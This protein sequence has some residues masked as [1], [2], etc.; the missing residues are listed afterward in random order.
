MT[1]DVNKPEESYL[2]KFARIAEEKRTSDLP[3]AYDLKPEPEPAETDISSQL[4]SSQSAREWLASLSANNSASAG[5]KAEEPA[6]KKAAEVSASVQE[7]KVASSSVSSTSS[8]SSESPFTANAGRDGY[9]EKKK[10]SPVW[11]FVLLALLLGLGGVAG[12]VFLARNI[13]SSAGQS[14]LSPGELAKKRENTLKLVQKYIEAGLYDKALS[15]LNDL[16]IDDPGDEAV[17]SIFDQVASLSRQSMALGGTSGFYDEQGNF[18]P[19]SIGPGGETGFY[20]SEGNFHA[21]TT[22]PGGKKGYYDSEGNFHEMSSATS[23][24]G[25]GQGAYP[26]AAGGGTAGFYDAQGNYHP[27]AVGPDGTVGYYGSDGKFHSANEPGVK[28]VP[29]SGAAGLAGTGGTAGFYDAQGNYHPA[30]V[31]PDGSVGYYDSTGKFHSA[32]E[33][34]VTAVPAAGAA[35]LAGMNGADS[36]SSMSD[37]MQATIDAL[38]GE[39]A[40]QTEE[41]VRTNQALRDELARQTA[42]SA[43]SNQ[44]L[45]DELA[46]QTAESAKSNQALRDEL[47][48]QNAENAKSTQALKDQL[49]KQTEENRKNVQAMNDLVR[50]QKE[51]EE[52]R[53]AAEAEEK[54]RQEAEAKQRAAEEKKRKE[55]EARKAAESAAAA[56]LIKD[57]NDEI[58]KGKAALNSGDVDEAMKHFAKAKS[59]LPANDK[60]FYAD[61]MGEMSSALYDA[62]QNTQDSAQK[63]KLM[64]QALGYANDSLAKDSS[65]PESHYIKAMDAFDSKN[66]AA[67]EAELKK[68]VAA[69][70][71]NPNY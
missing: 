36:S 44:A 20:D 43:K 6:P 22:G 70:P 66:W 50:A 61:K 64:Q 39:L 45:M 18:H 8:I 51:A 47:A 32:G 5:Y 53:R 12:G 3:S 60:E 1:N 16:M 4:S 48:R 57:I 26:G 35:G 41:S 59:M 65:N 21:V 11:L 62:S 27:V 38:K 37:A 40:R 17:S 24:A 14:R 34:G 71:T 69:D 49:A 58:A 68:A 55:E 42:E 29:A 52:A 31:G 13:S 7:T 33:P 19:A 54:Q 30:A 46:K 15:L 9:D 2:M 10:R 23:Y 28:A 56:K 67:A 25:A 63:K